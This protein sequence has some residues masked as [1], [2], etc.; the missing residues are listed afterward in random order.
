MVLR[1]SLKPNCGTLVNHAA[2]IFHQVTGILGPIWLR[3]Q[4]CA[5]TTDPRVEWKLTRPETF[6]HLELGVRSSPSLFSHANLFPV[7]AAMSVCVCVC[8]CVCVSW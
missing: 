4:V 5:G 3:G 1:K 8:V 7:Y 2:Q 6:S